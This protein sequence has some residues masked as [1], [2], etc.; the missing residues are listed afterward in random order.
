VDH[1]GDVGQYTSLALDGAGNPHISYHAASPSHDLKY[2]HWTG[3]DWDIQVVDNEQGSYTSLALDAAGNPHISYYGDGDLKFA[4]WTGSDWDIQAVGGEG[5]RYTSLAL[6]A[7]DH[8]HIS[9]Y[10]D[11]D[12]KYAHWTGSDW[13]IQTVDGEGDVGSWTSLALD[14]AGSPHI[15]YRDNTNAD[16]KY[17]RPYVPPLA[18]HKEGAPRDGLRFG[19]TLTYTLT[20]TG[21]GLSVRLVDPLPDNVDY[22]SGS[23]TGTLT[24]T[25]VYSPAVR[26]I[27]WYGTLVT[28]T[29][30]VIRFQ[31]APRIRGT[32]TLS[33]SPPI[34]NTAWL[35][36]TE[37]ERIVS[38]TVIV[39]GWY[40]YMPLVLQQVGMGPPEGLHGWVYENGQPAEGITVTLNFCKDYR[41]APGRPWNL[42]CWDLESF[43]ATTSSRGMYQFLDMPSTSLTRTQ[44]YQVLWENQGDPD[45]LA[46]WKTRRIDSYTSGTSVNIG[47]FD[48]MDIDLVSPVSG[49]VTGFPLT[50]EWGFRDEPLA[51]SYGLCLYGGFQPPPPMSWDIVGCDERLGYVNAH[52]FEDPFMG[53]DYGY[54]YYWYV[55]VWDSTRGKGASYQR[56]R[57][58][59]SA[60]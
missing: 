40:T 41:I 2:A 7:T 3:S 4:R 58:V 38:S 60:P 10:G 35:T 27:T 49:T 55:E 21:P 36:D 54:D 33:V 1:Q 20:L 34:V 29:T 17:A 59:F 46:Y 8:P 25:A 9:Y 32:G 47:N 50:F 16:L 15:S 24:P 43:I 57:V 45:R 37:Y 19:D 44:W 52:I 42:I 18:L 39:N 51:D 28:D 14:A 30:Q 12:L 5:G 53:V 23:I 26:A 6:D 13:D 11:G 56:N 48:V 22:V 31:V